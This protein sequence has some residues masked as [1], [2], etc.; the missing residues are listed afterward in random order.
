[1]QIKKIEINLQR[2]TF[3]ITFNDL[4]MAATSFVLSSASQEFCL[5][6]SCNSHK[7]NLRKVITKII[8]MTKKDKN[9]F[10]T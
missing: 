1:M 2:F 8:I 4:A 6:G 10:L 5:E 9:K 7:K 3:A